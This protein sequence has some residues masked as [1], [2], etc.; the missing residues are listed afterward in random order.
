[1]R[2]KIKPQTAAAEKAIKDVCRTTRT[3]H[4]AEDH[5][6]IVLEGVRGEDSIA[7]MCRCEGIADLSPRE[8][9]VKFSDTGLCGHFYI[10]T[11]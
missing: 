9:A 10:N 5:T 6:R 8:V 4:S 2:Q 7:A 3:H 11:R 1:M